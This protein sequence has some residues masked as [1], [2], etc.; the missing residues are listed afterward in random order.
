M[1][2]LEK[3]GIHESDTIEF[4][5]DIASFSKGE[6][7][8]VVEDDGTEFP[9]AKNSCGEVHAFYVD[10]VKKLMNPEPYPTMQEFLSEVDGTH[11]TAIERNIINDYTRRISPNNPL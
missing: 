6:R 9:F 4:V 10:R 8:I 2:P 11:V 1:T 7:A 5:E 3:R